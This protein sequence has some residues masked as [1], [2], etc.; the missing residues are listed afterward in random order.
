MVLRLSQHWG[1]DDNE[2]GSVRGR[3]NIGYH[4]LPNF[5]HDKDILTLHN[6]LLDGFCKT[7]A[8]FGFVAVAVCAVEQTVSNLE[9]VVDTFSY[10]AWGSLPCAWENIM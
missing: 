7:L 6:A 8:N 5:G 4:C 2:G 10:D 3:R 1:F 9:G